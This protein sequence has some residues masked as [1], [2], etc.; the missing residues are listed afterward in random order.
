MKKIYLALNILFLS[1]LTTS[2]ANV[3]L[4]SV[5][6][7]IIGPETALI[8][9]TQESEAGQDTAPETAPPAPIADDDIRSGYFNVDGV[10]YKLP[11][12]C[13]EFINNGWEIDPAH[14]GT[15]LASGNTLETT[16][17]KGSGTLSI[18]IGNP[19][20]EKTH[21]NSLPVIRLIYYPQVPENSQIKVE[22][23]K[24]VV[25]ST[26]TFADI[27]AA[28]GEADSIGASGPGNPYA[29][30]VYSYRSPH[31]NGVRMSFLVT[32]GGA[33]QLRYFIISNGYDVT[34][35]QEALRAAG[36]PIA[37]PTKE[38]AAYQAPTS[39][40]NDITSGIIEYDGD[41]YRLPVPVSAM[42][43]NGWTL[44]TTFPSE[45]E[46]GGHQMVYLSRGDKE[47]YQFIVNPGT[48]TAVHS[49]CF[50]DRWNTYEGAVISGIRVGDS[51]AKLLEALNGM[52]Y[53]HEP[54]ISY[55]EDRYVLNL[56]YSDDMVRID[57][58]NETDQVIYIN[59]K[60]A[61][62]PK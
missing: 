47:I 27:E 52:D 21:V 41:L 36:T 8:G 3:K 56:G 42:Q 50:A 31:D 17:R 55:H 1:A 62:L 48:E 2:C 37:E 51:R 28:H 25:V 4:A 14:A 33:P 7:N 29:K 53:E 34:M 39:L 16:L 13:Q 46:P 15:Q 9:Q 35:K 44:H 32:E 59:L 60:K 45:I 23:P 43:K 11:V 61:E 20:D 58:S 18:A 49:N 38:V 26:G 10:T 57:V 24:G 54:E 6:L 22:L 5:G 12:S 30:D 40:G 19:G